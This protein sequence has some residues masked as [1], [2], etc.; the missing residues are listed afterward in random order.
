M[1]TKVFRTFIGSFGIEYGNYGIHSEIDVLWGITRYLTISFNIQIPHLWWIA[2]LKILHFEIVV[3]A[4]YL[5]IELAWFQ[6]DIHWRWFQGFITE[7]NKKY[8]KKRSK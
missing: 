6:I 2:L 5:K 4:W 1:R 7:K 3:S 8:A